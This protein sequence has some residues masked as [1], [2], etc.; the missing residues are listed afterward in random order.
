MNEA[1]LSRRNNNESMD[2]FDVGSRRRMQPLKEAPANGLQPQ[3][4]KG[5]T[6]TEECS[7]TSKS[8]LSQHSPQQSG[9]DLFDILVGDL[10]VAVV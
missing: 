2:S 7:I 9:W 6:V 8:S 10:V 1:L 5:R 4:I 3:P